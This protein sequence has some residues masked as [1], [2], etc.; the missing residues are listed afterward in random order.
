VRVLVDP[1]GSVIGALPENP[2]PSKYFARLADQAA[3]EWKF[4]PADQQATRV[5]LVRFRFTR[6]GITTQ[7]TAM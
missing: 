3:R 6:D 5:W 1:A 4:V 7:V 2:G